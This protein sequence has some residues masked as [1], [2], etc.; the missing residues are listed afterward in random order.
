MPKVRKD[1]IGRPFLCRGWLATVLALTSFI[2][3]LPFAALDFDDH[4]DG[5]MLAQAIAISDGLAIHSDIFGQYG[6]VTPWIHS[7][8]LSLPL[9]PAVALRVGNSALIAL[10]IFFLADFARVAPPVWRVS[11]KA[12]LLAAATWLIFAD[13]WFGV[14][15]LP[16]SSVVV[17]VLLV[18]SLYALARAASASTAEK[19]GASNAWALL[20]G[21]L[22]GVAP[23]SR[24]NVGLAAMVIT[25]TLLTW[26]SFSRR[27]RREFIG[28][29]SVAAIGSFLLVPLVLLTT[30][31]LGDFVQ[32]A[33]LWPV[34]WGV[35]ATNDWATGPSL[36]KIFSSQIL[37]VGAFLSYLIVSWVQ[38]ARGAN[39]TL[40]F[41]ASP[42]AGVVLGLV[43]VVWEVRNT[44][45]KFLSK[46]VSDSLAWADL[47]NL[48]FS[49]YTEFLHFFLVLAAV[50]SCV[51]MT[52]ALVSLMQRR[53][54]WVW[55]FPLVLSVFVLAMF[56][57]LVP[58]WDSR[59]IWWGLPLGLL[60]VY[61]VIDVVQS[62][63]AKTSTPLIALLPIVG[64]VAVLALIAAPV[65]LAAPRTQA[66]ADSVA[67]G[68]RLGVAEARLLQNEQDF[69]RKH[70]TVGQR[71]IFITA[72][73]HFSVLGNE[74]S[75]ADPYFVAW[76]PVP[77]L[78][79]RLRDTPP[80]FV[81][82]GWES[83]V[84]TLL[85]EGYELV[86]ESTRIVLFRHRS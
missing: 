35:S 5:Y 23:F 46:V 63:Q 29:Y 6:P 4:H 55:L 68:M 66:P 1:K 67:Q 49:T 81:E 59:H 69:L 28:L 27:L 14:T 20:G 75:S 78:A 50:L 56:T 36:I 42:V 70:L 60:L 74:F 79:T 84:P 31:S 10:T 53:D 19:R 22:L 21:A 52:K 11:C 82:K 76:G 64:F 44:A 38:P 57:Q 61:C 24:L 77:E 47:R 39:K 37:P 3:L 30:D 71:A 12:G 43:I 34:Q 7:L 85:E 25:V 15:M 32:Q 83:R 18:G 16:W 86:D 2:V 8:F 54:T 17:M 26:V 45:P 33:L 51:V 40:G 13:V 65:H 48:L 80:I 73:G 9:G 58:T 72:Y 41:L 62:S